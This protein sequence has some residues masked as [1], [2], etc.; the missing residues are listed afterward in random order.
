MKLNINFYYK[1]RYLP[2]KRHRNYR[3]RKL[4]GTTTVTIKE[5]TAEEFPI[6]FIIHDMK[7]VCEGMKCYEDYESAKCDFRMFD[8]EIRT[9]KGKLY[10]PIRITHGSAISTEFETV[11]NMISNI[12]YY[13]VRDFWL[14]EA[15]EPF[16]EDSIV[17]SDNSASVIKSLR[18]NPYAKVYFDG[19]LWSVIG[20][21]R[22]N[23]TTFGLGHNHGGTGFF[24]EYGYNPNIPSKNYFSALQRD[25][26]IAYGK[27]V[28]TR[29]G[30]TN[31]VEGMG[32][33]DIIEVVMPEMVKVKPNKQHG[34]G[35]EFMNMMDSVI[36]NSESVGEAGLLCMAL[37]L[38]N[39]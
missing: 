38:A 20:E 8:E 4:S 28:A 39:M 11:E 35:C 12:E 14:P 3:E 34:N 26:A 29:R 23:I 33:H 31:S 30:D 21:P 2:T 1:Q 17:V 15:D 6:A 7:S 9:F 24:I 25:E 27:Y 13:T 5:L 10:S 32:D 36:D 18:S 16:T 22:Y 19:K 37:A